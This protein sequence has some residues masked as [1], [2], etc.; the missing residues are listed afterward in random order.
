MAANEPAQERQG[1]LGY[2]LFI[3]ALSILSIA[4]L[5]IGYL[6]IADE[7]LQTILNVINAIFLPIFLGDFVWRLLHASPKGAYFFRGFGWADLLSSLPLTQTKI[8]RVFRL[9]R[10]GRFVREFGVGN[11]WRDFI[12]HRA[13]NTL[14]TV[15]FLVICVVEFG[16]LAALK[17][18]QY[19]PGANITSASDAIWYV[20]VTI[21][22]VG[23]GDRYPVT[24]AGRMVGL[25]IMMAGVGLFGTLAGFLSNKFLTPPEAKA[26]EAA[27]AE[28]SDLK[29]YVT[30][31][32][33]MLA[34]Q[35][36]ATAALHAKLDEIE[37]LL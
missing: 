30:E 13:D 20:W 9:W 31:L 26:E 24:N 7:G 12:R 18:E 10:V 33:H 3:A 1:S 36:R 4:N 32:R 17:F 11:L 2:E 34:T 23:Y 5:V 35:E 21:T 22:T 28:P 15:V 16:A 25:L 14:L 6:W 37:R 27:P 19:A 8:L 29:T